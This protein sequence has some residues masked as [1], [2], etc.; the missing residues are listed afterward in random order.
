MSRTA[1]SVVTSGR[2]G[3]RELVLVAG[4]AVNFNYFANDGKVMIVAQ[5][6]GASSYTLTFTTQKT[7]DGL[8][9]PD[10]TITIPAGEFALVGP[11]PKSVYNTDYTDD[12]TVVHEDVVFVAA[13]N[14][15]VK[16][17]AIKMGA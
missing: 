14:A 15:A 1:L 5:N 16:V 17:A 7:I 3:D 2:T 11:F 9:I 4:D 13:E 6:S 8:A 10:L 12:E